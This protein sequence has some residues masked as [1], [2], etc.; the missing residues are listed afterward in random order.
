M[1]QSEMPKIYF[2]CSQ[3]LL[4]DLSALPDLTTLA[5]TD[6]LLLELELKDTIDTG[7]LMQFID[8]DT[9]DEDN[10]TTYVILLP[11]R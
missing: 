6:S 8:S 7:L 10:T 1:S 4:L 9:K 2:T 5:P 11:L 3:T